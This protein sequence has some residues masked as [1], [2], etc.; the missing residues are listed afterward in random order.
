ML[1][2]GFI[3]ERMVVRWSWEQDGQLLGRYIYHGVYRMFTAPLF[4]YIDYALKR[5]RLMRHYKVEPFLVFDGGQ[6]PAKMGTE[7]DRERFFDTSNVLE[8]NA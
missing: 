2:F 4:R 3:V 6:L 8:D 1:T 7:K 5:I